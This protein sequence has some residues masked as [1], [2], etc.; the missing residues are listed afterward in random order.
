MNTE[1][2]INKFLGVHPVTDDGWLP[3]KEEMKNDLEKLS[4]NHF[5]VR[6]MEFAGVKAIKPKPTKTKTYFINSPIE[7]IEEWA[8]K[9]RDVHSHEFRKNRTYGLEG[10]RSKTFQFV[11]KFGAIEIIPLTFISIKEI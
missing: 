9:Q 1:Q 11:S 6:V 5:I 10:T 7:E 3:I 4:R 8:L 2:F